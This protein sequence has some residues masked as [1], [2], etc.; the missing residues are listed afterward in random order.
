MATHS[1]DKLSGSITGKGIRVVAT[2]SLGTLLHTAVAG[3]GADNYDEI[4]LQAMN[5]DTVARKLTIEWG[6]ISV[7]DDIIELTLEPEAGLVW[8]V[9]GNLLQNGL[10]VRA[11]CSAANVVTIHGYVNKVRP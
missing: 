2:A 5:S 11:F 6:D 10:Q 9:P 7:P 8:V 3:T 4:Y 1:K